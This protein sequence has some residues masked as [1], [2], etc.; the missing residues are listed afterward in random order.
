[1]YSIMEITL[2]SLQKRLAEKELSLTLTDA[3]KDFVLENGY[4]PVY[5]ARP[6]KRFIQH[7]VETMIAR[8]ILEKTPSPGTE[9]VIDSD[10]D[11]LFFAQ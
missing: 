2:R 4:D 9:I 5:G 8:Y 3:A 6:L 10:G 1:M 7:N 11:K